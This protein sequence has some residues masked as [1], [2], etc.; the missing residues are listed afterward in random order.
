[1]VLQCMLSSK[2]FRMPS[3]FMPKLIEIFHFKTHQCQFLHSSSW[4]SCK[5]VFLVQITFKNDWEL[6]FHPWLVNANPYI[7]HHNHLAKMLAL[8]KSHSKMIGIFH[9]M[10]C[11]RQFIH[12]SSWPSG[13]NAC[14][15][16]ITIF[17]IITILQKCYPCTNPLQKRLG[18]SISLHSSSY[19]QA[20]MLSL[21]QY[22]SKT[23]VIFHL[24]TC[25]KIW[26]HNWY[27]GQKT[28]IKGIMRQ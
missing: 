20:E 27:S 7:L 25:H 10:T 4:P 21:N 3:K 1:M 14:L 28:Y 24:K 26:I 22:S 15:V 23:I 8:Y 5:N 9:F 11:Q 17:F 6:P 19:H 16:K 2:L 12:S 18:S 13:K